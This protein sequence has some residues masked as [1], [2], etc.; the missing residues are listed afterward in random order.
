M[1]KKMTLFA[2]CFMCVGLM[3]CGTQ[4]T[5]TSVK[6]TETST[7]TAAEQ[8]S[9]PT[10]AAQQ[11]TTEAATQEQTEAV[12]TEIPETTTSVQTDSEALSEDQALDAIKNY[13][14]TNNPELKNMASSDEYTIYWN[15]TSNTANEI[16]V[17]Y[18]SYTGAETRYYIDPVS[19]ETYSTE[20]V[21]G[22]I[23]EEQRTEESFN[24]KDYMAE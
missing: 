2:L 3:A 1:K 15:V 21:P 22:I 20:L 23:D 5:N 4:T 18:R 13:C 7:T 17:L 14:F 11:E 9:K 24:V 19:G 12:Q 8:T 6:Q 10:E 16:V